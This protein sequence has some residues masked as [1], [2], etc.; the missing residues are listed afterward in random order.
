[1]ILETLLIDDDPE[2]GKTL[3]LLNSGRWIRHFEQAFNDKQGL[4]FLEKCKF[5]L[6]VVDMF[7]EGAGATG[8]DLL[9]KIKKLQPTALV[10]MLTSHRDQST[11]VLSR[12]SGAQDYIIKTP[13]NMN[14]VLSSLEK[15]I[16]GTVRQNEM[17]LEARKIADKLG[18][19]F[20]SQQMEQVLVTALMAHS[21][22]K[23]DVLIRGETGVGKETIAEIVG[24]R[25]NKFPFIVV[26]CA[27]LNAN[28]AESEL[29]GHEKGSYTGAA[30]TRKGQLQLANGGDIFIDEVDSLPLETQ[31]KLLRALENR[32]IK[33]LGSNEIIKLNLR[34]IAATNADLNELVSQGKMRADFL[35]R[36]R[37]LEINIPPLRD[38]PDDI[39]PIVKK[40]LDSNYPEISID[41][42]CLEALSAYH[43]PE[44]VRELKKRINAMA[45][46][47]TMDGTKKIGFSHLPE[48]LIAE[49]VATV[50]SRR[51]EINDYPSKN[52]E[53]SQMAMMEIGAASN[54]SESDY[55]I[56]P[57]T[58]NLAEAKRI[59]ER[60]FIKNRIQSGVANQKQLADKLRIPKSTLSRLM[61]E[62][63]LS[64]FEKNDPSE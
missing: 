45:T 8:L 64:I 48:D 52:E 32:E 54:K 30:T 17:A 35:A 36:L 38:R 60:D 39:G 50:R 62:H 61:G 26:N 34:V 22:P 57:S 29:F 25:R 55:F 21:S 46:I 41:P 20:A 44:N 24:R 15:L 1:M 19:P 3:N 42:L 58:A 14:L 63:G 47:A 49:L 31:A 13:M 9:P 51:A 53:K 7:L 37:G 28:L 59:F 40:V 33:R 2:V 4:N 10:V 12:Y 23:V 11:A 16:A 6:I 18:Y 27:N 43:W 5:D 56:I